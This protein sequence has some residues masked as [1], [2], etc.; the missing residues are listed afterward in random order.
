MINKSLSNVNTAS[1]K[2]I[3]ISFLANIIS[4]DIDTAYSY[5]SSTLQRSFTKEQISDYI[6]EIH[7]IIEN[8]Y[9]GNN[10]ENTLAVLT[11]Q[12]EH[13]NTATAYSFEIDSMNKINN[14]TPI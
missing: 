9:F 6:G 7:T 10:M 8:K 1:P 13:V 5:L 12:S 3:T 2:D 4:G 11:K 14:I